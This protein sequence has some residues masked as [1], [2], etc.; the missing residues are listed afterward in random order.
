LQF[1]SERGGNDGEQQE[2][3][4]SLHKGKLAQRREPSQ[5]HRFTDC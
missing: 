1:L 5:R 2:S 3:D 4:K